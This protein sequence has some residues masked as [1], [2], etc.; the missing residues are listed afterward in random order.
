[1]RGSK[2]KNKQ[3][4]APEA[5]KRQAAGSKVT[6][7]QKSAQEAIA[8]SKANKAP[9]A[10]AKSKRNQVPAVTNK[11][12]PPGHTSNSTQ[13]RGTMKEGQV[14]FVIYHHLNIFHDSIVR[15]NKFCSK[16]K[17]KSKSQ[18]WKALR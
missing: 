11:V 1:M 9:A 10:T 3:A 7:R 13:V 4:A 14:C 16:M 17:R 12:H 15:T 18:Q 5:K 6:N 2:P 8:E